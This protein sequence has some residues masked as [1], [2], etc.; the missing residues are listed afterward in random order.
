MATNMTQQK[1]L[2]CA[3]AFIFIYN[4]AI[5][6]PDVV[7]GLMAGRLSWCYDECAM[8]KVLLFTNNVSNDP[9]TCVSPAVKLVAACSLGR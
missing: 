4:A 9:Q 1:R 3:A 7:H 5:A 8:T 6:A 2:R